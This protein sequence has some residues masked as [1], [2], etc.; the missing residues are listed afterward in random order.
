MADH[1]NHRSQLSQTFDDQYS[2]Q[3]TQN[4]APLTCANST[5]IIGA[6]ASG[7]SS[8]SPMQSSGGGVGEAPEQQAVSTVRRPRG[9]PPGSKNKPKQ[10]VVADRDDETPNHVI[11]EVAAG[12]D[13]VDSVMQFA[14]RRRRGISVL[15]GSGSISNVTL[16]QPNPH[17]TTCT[18]NGPLSLVSLSGTYIN[19]DFPPPG[20]SPSSSSAIPP[21]GYS[22]F[23][24]CLSNA[25]NCVFGGVVVGKLIAASVVVVV[26]TTFKK[27]PA[28]FMI[29]QSTEI[30]VEGNNSFDSVI[31]NCGICN[32]DVAMNE[33]G[34]PS[35]PF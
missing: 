35:S 10:S 14:R 29:D 26:A 33:I 22:S 3:S 4:L 7:S 30:E 1:T 9:R 16:L 21:P 31:A 13:V 5:P 8:I 28:T 32:S 34:C 6:A 27:A 25:Q 12:S 2:A 24:I 23:G 20:D 15:S 17:P 11:L 18:I 19:G